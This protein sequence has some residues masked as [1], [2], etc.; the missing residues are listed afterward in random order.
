[1]CIWKIQKMQNIEN[2][3]IIQPISIIDPNLDKMNIQD[4]LKQV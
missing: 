4:R 2:I 1:M 3:Y